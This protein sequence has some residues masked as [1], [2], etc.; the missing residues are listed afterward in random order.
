MSRYS[1]TAFLGHPGLS[2]AAA[3]A[4][5]AA[6]A[7]AAVVAGHHLPQ[8][9]HDG[10]HLHHKK[11]PSPSMNNYFP[12][13]HFSCGCYYATALKYVRIA[14]NIRVGF[15]LGL[16]SEMEY[17]CHWQQ[18]TVSIYSSEALSHRIK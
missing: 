3:A 2:P 4:H 6:A 10:H 8:I 12:I 18:R 9:K 5:A 17:K 16:W 1:P 13:H 15:G 7:Q 11:D 14:F